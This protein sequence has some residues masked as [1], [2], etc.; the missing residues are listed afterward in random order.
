[1]AVEKDDEDV[2]SACTQARPATHDWST[3]LLNFDQKALSCTCLG[4][5]S[6][7]IA[8][9]RHLLPLIMQL[10]LYIHLYPLP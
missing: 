9:K 5:G 7:S 8:T 2:Y 6:L 3:I 1:M 10:R 4:L